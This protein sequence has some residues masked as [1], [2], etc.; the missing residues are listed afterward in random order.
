MIAS[1]ILPS[2]YTIKIEGEAVQALIPGDFGINRIAIG[3]KDFETDLMA[4][5]ALHQSMQFLSS[6]PVIDIS[7]LEETVDFNPEFFPS[8]TPMEL[9]Q[10]Q[11]DEIKRAEDAA[12]EMP[13]IPGQQAVVLTRMFDPLGDFIESRW[14]LKSPKMVIEGKVGVNPDIYMTQKGQEIF[15]KKNSITM[16]TTQVS[17][18]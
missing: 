6:A 14:T 17:L 18:H 5:D 9:T 16:P 10:E 11:K 4:T 3:S 12:D 2:F 8:L 15:N 7:E 13:E 1:K